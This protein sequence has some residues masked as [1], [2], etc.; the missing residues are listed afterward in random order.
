M[1]FLD[2][3]YQFSLITPINNKTSIDKVSVNALHLLSTNRE[4]SS[5][6]SISSHIHPLNRSQVMADY[7]NILNLD[8]EAKF[9]QPHVTLP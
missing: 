2:G 5:S 4:I 1:L 6:R 8:L 9:R 7:D 3:P